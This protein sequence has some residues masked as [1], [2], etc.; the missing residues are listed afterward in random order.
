MVTTREKRTYH[1]YT[2][3]IDGTIVSPDG[4]YLEGYCFT[5]P[6]SHININYDGKSYKKLKAKLMYE[7]FSGEEVSREY[8]IRFK[9]GDTKNCA[10]TNL[11]LESRKEF[12]KKNPKINKKKFNADVEA[13]IRELYLDE[14]GKKKEDAPSLRQLANI[15]N[16]SLTTIQKVL[17]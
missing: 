10:F 5:Y 15:Y 11:Y 13:E 12:V 6:Y 2:F 9:D 14:N 3:Y 16:C 1:G 8:I 17:E 4:N 7:L